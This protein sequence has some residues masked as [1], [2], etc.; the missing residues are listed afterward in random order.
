MI[1][2]CPR[3]DFL[4][5]VIFTIWSLKNLPRLAFLQTQD[6]C[7]Q[8]TMTLFCPRIDFLMTVIFIIWSLKNLPRV[9]FLQTQDRCLQVTMILFCPRIDFLMTVIFTIWSLKNLPRLAFLQWVDTYRPM[10]NRDPVRSK[11]QI[12]YDSDIQSMVIEEFTSPCFSATDRCF[13]T[14]KQ[15]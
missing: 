7:L 8:V 15:P 9:A 12:S 4:M 14:P 1:L 5:T 10:G 2:F 13:K 6:R 3:I 11:N